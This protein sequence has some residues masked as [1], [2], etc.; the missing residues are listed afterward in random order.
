[1]VAVINFPIKTNGK[2]YEVMSTGFNWKRKE[3]VLLSSDKC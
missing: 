2:F 3:V 1:M